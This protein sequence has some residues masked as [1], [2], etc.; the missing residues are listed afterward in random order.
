MARSASDRLLCQNRLRQIGIALH[1]Y[2]DT[3]NAFPEGKD[4]SDRVTYI[5]SLQGVSWLAKILP[6]VEQEALWEQTEQ[7]AKQDRVPWHNPPHV[8]LSTVI[9]L[10][11]CP[12]DPRVVTPLA[13]NYPDDP[14]IVPRTDVI[15]AFTS[16]KGVQGSGPVGPDNGV[17]P[18]AYSVRIGD[19]LD[20][21]SQTLMVGERPPSARLDSGWWYT[22]HWS[23]Y[24]HDFILRAEMYTESTEC[25]PPQ[26]AGRFMFGPGRFDNQC[27]MYHYWSPHQGGANF[28]FADGSVRFLPYSLSPKLAAL[29]TRNGGEP[30]AAY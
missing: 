29:A 27:D 24:T 1:A 3:H 12:S 18:Y 10:Y 21:T 4:Y 15:A 17:L 19:I 23:V 20:G 5:N 6:F 13:G 11:T 14:R 9:P 25:V 2:H 30:E 16:F 8:G 7:A 28:T 22:S 26:P